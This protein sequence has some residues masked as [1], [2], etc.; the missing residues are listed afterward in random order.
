MHRPGLIGQNISYIGLLVHKA[1]RYREIDTF[2][3]FHLV[4]SLFVGGGEENKVC[5][6]L[7]FFPLCSI[8]MQ[9]GCL[10]LSY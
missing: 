9:N 5:S 1:K 10:P 3:F 7:L 4:V 8:A 6:L 2:C